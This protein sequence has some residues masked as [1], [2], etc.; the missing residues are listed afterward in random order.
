MKKRVIFMGTPHYAAQ[1]LKTLIKAD[2]IELAAVFTQPD[3]KVGRGQVLTYPNVKQFLLDNN[4]LNIPLFQPESLKDKDLIE[5]IALLKPDFIIVAA[6]GK[7]LPQEILEIAPCI[8]LHASILPKYRGASPIQ[9]TILNGD[10][11]GGVTAMKME[12]GLDTGDILGFSYVLIEDLS[13][14]KLFDILAEKASELA[15]KVIRLY[16]LVL[17][18]KQI[19]AISS[20]T[21]KIQKENGLV[22]FDLSYKELK[23]KLLAFMPWPGLFLSNGLKLK[24]FDCECFNHNFKSGEI[25]T[26]DD[27]KG[28][29]TAACKGGFVKIFKVQAPSKAEI[30]AVAYVNGKR[31]KVGDTFY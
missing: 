26:I 10:N 16:E 18:I 24:S 8:N 7:M 1:I 5:Q 20:K 3:K 30:T 2:D 25:V 21:G 4:L 12:I 27:N 6:Y 15:L 17:Q 22:S 14:D 23:Q 28:F 19:D 11:Y 29:V 13:A 31:I 9:Q